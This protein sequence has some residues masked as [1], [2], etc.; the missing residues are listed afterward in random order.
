MAFLNNRAVDESSKP[1]CSLALEA[2][3]NKC[4]HNRSPLLSTGPLPGPVPDASRKLFD[5]HQT[6]IRML[7]S[8]LQ[9]IV[10][11]LKGKTVK[12]R[13]EGSLP[14]V[15]GLGRGII[16]ID[17]RKNGSQLEMLTLG[18]ADPGLGGG[19]GDGA[20]QSLSSLHNPVWWVQ[21]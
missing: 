10:H 4:T 1:S 5:T 2:E 12:W 13:L 17:D 7:L 18:P 21:Q 20:L 9:Y 19:A 16:E 14:H 3:I 6:L 8:C 15:T 11:N